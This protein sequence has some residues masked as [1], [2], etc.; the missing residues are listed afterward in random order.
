MMFRIEAGHKSQ[1][2]V[3]EPGC[4]LVWLRGQPIGAVVLSEDSRRAN[5]RTESII[6]SFMIFICVELTIDVRGFND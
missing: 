4:L 3:E 5:L 1:S 2:R 6:C